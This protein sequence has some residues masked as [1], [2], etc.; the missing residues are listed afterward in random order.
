MQAKNLFNLD[1]KINFKIRSLIYFLKLYY[2]QYIGIF[3][4]NLFVG[5][6]EPLNLAIFLPIFNGI[7][8]LSDFGADNGLINILNSLIKVVPFEDKIISACV[9]LI[10]ITFVRVIFGLLNDYLIAFMSGRVM[11]DMRRRIIEKYF[12]A[13]YQYFL[14][15]KQGDL[16]FRANFAASKIAGIL[17]RLPQITTEIIK[18]LCVLALLLYINLYLTLGVTALGFMYGFFILWLSKKHIYPL[19]RISADLSKKLLTIVSEFLVG[20]KHIRVNNS[21]NRWE[22]MHDCTNRNSSRAYALSNFAIYI[23]NNIMQLLSYTVIGLSVIFFRLY[24]PDRFLSY[25]PILAV[26][27]MGFQRIMPSLTQ[28]GN[29]SMRIVAELPLCELVYA[30]LKEEVEEKRPGNKKYRAFNKSISFESVAFSYKE[31]GA[32]LKKIN[33]LEFKKNQVT[34]IVGTSGSGKTTIINLILGLFYPTSGRI[35]I[36]GV[37]L[38]E[39]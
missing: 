37:D 18:A 35:L 6:L 7:F 2:L 22:K 4:L 29:L 38:G 39:Y 21:K 16:I 26:F 3:C 31:R 24:L 11:Y 1:N 36:D 17:L 20:I 5:F 25:L 10:L 27:V 33:N 28:V 19:G 14:D 32:L 8:G 15:N 34:A 9:L 23:P 30:T 12:N 13:P